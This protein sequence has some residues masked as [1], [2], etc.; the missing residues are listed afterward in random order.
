MIPGPPVPTVVLPIVTGPVIATVVGPAPAA[1]ACP[2]EP[3][4]GR[5]IGSRSKLSA[6]ATLKTATTSTNR[7]L[8]IV[9]SLALLPQSWHPPSGTSRGRRQITISR[10]DSD[11]T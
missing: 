4:A 7:T 1:P 3:D 2:A 8:R 6:Q 5:R 9:S 10:N 11:P